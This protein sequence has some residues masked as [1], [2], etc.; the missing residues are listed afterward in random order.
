MRDKSPQGLG[1]DVMLN[2]F[3]IGVRDM[4]GHA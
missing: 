4:G 1:A 2:S 3:R